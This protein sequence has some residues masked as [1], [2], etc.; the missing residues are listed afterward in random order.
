MEIE[1]RQHPRRVEARVV[2]SLGD[3]WRMVAELRFALRCPEPAEVWYRGHAQDGYN[4]KPAL[5]RSRRGVRAEQQLFDNYRSFKPELSNWE[6]LFHMQH[7]GVPTRLL[8]W[9][10]DLATALYLH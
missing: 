9:T 10:A 3:I 2:D 4:L 6:T 1:T 5:F 8:D 7:Y